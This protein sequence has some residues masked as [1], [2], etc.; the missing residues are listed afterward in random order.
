VPVPA[1]LAGDPGLVIDPEG[2]PHVAFRDYNQKVL[3]YGYKNAGEWYLQIVSDVV[4]YGNHHEVFISPDGLP[5]IVYH[6]DDHMKVL[7]LVP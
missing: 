1:K 2:R 5:V 4:Y 3:W 6:D 7:T